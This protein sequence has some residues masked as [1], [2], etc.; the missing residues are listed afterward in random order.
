MLT[1]NINTTEMTGF[2]LRMDLSPNTKVL[3][4]PKLSLILYPLLEVQ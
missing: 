4:D 1:T 3:E 2:D